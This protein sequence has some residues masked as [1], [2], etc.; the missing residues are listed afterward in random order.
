VA[1]PFRYTFILISVAL[2]TGLAAAGGWRYARASAPVNGPIIL[3]SIDSLRADHLPVYGYRQVKTPA[4]DALAADGV[5]FE[6]AYSH[7]PQTL[8]AHASLLSGRLP[9]ETGVR[10]NVG[11]AVKGSERLLPQMLHERGY[12][13]GGVVSTYVLRKATGVNQGFDFFDDEMPADSPELGIDQGQRDGAESEAIAERWLDQQRS[14]RVFLFLHLYEPH[15]PYSPPAAY[16]EYTAYDGEIAYA[17]EIVG[18]LI[19]YLKSHQLYDRSTIVLLSDHGEG[20]GDHGEQA[21]GLFLYDEAIHVPL[22]V[23][24]AG[25]TDGGRRIRDIV[26]H[27]DIAPT[28]LDLAKAPI[29]GNLRGRS[30]KPVLEGTGTLAAQ[31]VY[32]EAPYGR[33]H[34]GWSE[35]T[36]LTDARYRFIQAPVPEL[37]DLERDPHERQNVAGDRGTAQAH[38]ALGAALGKVVAGV[39]IAAPGK[40]T[41]EDRERLQALGY[42]GAQ[43][44]VTKAPAATLPDPKDTRAVLET[45]REAVDLGVHRKWGQA[46]ARFQRILREHPAMVDVWGQVGALA[47]RAQRYDQ[48]I[49]AYKH[50]IDLE[51]E[52]PA[53][54]LGAAA[55]MLRLRKL[56][57]ARA[58]AQSGA[59]VAAERDAP[60]RAAAHELLARIALARRDAEGARREAGLARENDPKLPLPAYIEAR[61]LYDQG[62]YAEA[63]ALFQQAITELKRSGD[64]TI[65]NLHLY[66]AEA[67]V[68]LER[69]ADAER[70]FIEELKV[71]S[72]NTRARAG[73]AT[74]YHANGQDEDVARV[75]GDLVRITPTPDTYALAARLWT[76]FGNR[77]QADAVRAQARRALNDDPA[78]SRRAAR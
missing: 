71:D 45:Y 75:I 68:H 38:D 33:Y 52:D 17:D 16:A 15:A 48:A 5:V 62:Q 34:F 73:L 46:I 20:L 24:Q 74:L 37:Y 32:S 40:V 42:V 54:Y 41:A 55:A 8:P 57:D 56:D 11:F 61:L 39:A 18:R 36:A 23:K 26:Q 47:I 13:T 31:A 28:I 69:S 63:L 60:S 14:Q 21:H 19:R 9:F 12:S 2:A 3:I 65:V 7:S 4:I 22:I 44:G 72:Q 43:T 49:D 64:R 27:V 70:E 67:L 78:P 77:Q 50:M 59:D 1:R 10:D 66:T 76:T 53:G 51:P 30:L 25:S 29:A 58:H 6:R 35:L